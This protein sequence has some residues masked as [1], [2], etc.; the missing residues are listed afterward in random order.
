MPYIKEEDR[1]KIDPELRCLLN[2]L[3]KSID[4]GSY[5]YI[6]TRIIH[7]FILTNGLRYVNVN[8]AIGIMDCA[9]MELYRMVAG[10]YEDQ[11][12]K[13]NGFIS[14]LDEGLGWAPPTK[15]L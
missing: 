3:D 2:K 6:L 5:N 14:D 4:V 8:A 11:K 13:S 7:H 1:E 10:P 12:I 15:S 9:K